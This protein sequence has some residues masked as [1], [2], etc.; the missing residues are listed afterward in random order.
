ML[1]P[2]YS[3]YTLVPERAEGIAIHTDRGVYLDTYAGIGVL[4]LGHGDREV[5]RA[6]EAKATRYVHLSNYF[7]DPDGV[8]M[9]EQL[10]AR[11][12]GPGSVYFSNSG[13]EAVEAALKAVKKSRKGSIVSFEGDFHGRT[14]GALSVTW[15][16]AIRKPF[17][18]LLSDCVFL[19]RRGDALRA[20]AR[21]KTVAAV[22][23]ECIQ[24][25]SGVLPM[26]GDLAD[27]VR[28]VHRDQGALIVA[29]E[30]Q[31]GLGRT[32]AFFAYEHFGL[33]P[34]IVTMGKGLGG[35]LPLGATLFCGWEPFGPGDH[36]STFAP[37]PVSLAAG[38]VVL[39]RLT[40]EFLHEVVRKGELLA[41]R[42]AALPWARDV[43]ALGLMIGV[44]ASDAAEVRRK[45][46]ERRVLLNVAGGAVRFLPALTVTD[47]EIDKMV[48]L[49]DFS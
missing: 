20:F 30:I 4:P 33:C 8:W 19:P 18:P 16:P 37:N 23:L 44:S 11:T 28:A 25:N 14:L 10:L 42:L 1:S 40:P 47:A 13:A 27:A 43:R 49:L 21:E 12:G 26:D 32:G 29:D 48:R 46:F 35:G 38:G 34:D 9:A 39:R 41:K 24:G 45:A 31:T 7:V 3:P 36:G 2:V 22:V 6:M 15:G 5:L 17:E